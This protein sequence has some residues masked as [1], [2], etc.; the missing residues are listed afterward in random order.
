MTFRVRTNTECGL[1][2]GEDRGAAA[3]A[4]EADTEHRSAAGCGD[5]ASPRNFNP[6]GYST[7]NCPA[8]DAYRQALKLRP[9]DAA[10]HFNLAIALRKSGR[11]K[12]AESAFA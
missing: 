4:R 8:F 6:C 10:T 12:E 1:P 5:S 2:A 11:E 9:D 3:G 7:S